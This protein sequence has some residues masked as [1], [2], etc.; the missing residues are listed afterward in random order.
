[1]EKQ[2]WLGKGEEKGEIKE[3]EISEESVRQKSPWMI[4]YSDSSFLFI[5][6]FTAIRASSILSHKPTRTNKNKS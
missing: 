1:M 5:F 2:W 3:A 4:A 6:L